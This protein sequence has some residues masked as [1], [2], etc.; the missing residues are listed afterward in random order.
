MKAR[1]GGAVRLIAQ[2]V[3]PVRQAG[4]VVRGNPVRFRDCP[5]AV[6]GND[7]RHTHWTSA[8]LGAAG[9]GSDGQ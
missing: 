9:P 8:A 7:R 1:A 4:G 5:A 6:S 3:R 2:L